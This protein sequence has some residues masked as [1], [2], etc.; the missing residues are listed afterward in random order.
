MYTKGYGWAN[1]YHFLDPETGV[2]LVF[3]SQLVPPRDAE[4]LKLWD[5][6]EGIIYSGLTDSS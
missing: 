4:M 6:L 5:E 1:T 2:A 3:G